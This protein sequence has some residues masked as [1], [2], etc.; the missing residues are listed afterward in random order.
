MGKVCIACGSGIAEPK[1]PMEESED[2]P[3]CGGNGT[4]KK[5]E[6]SEEGGSMESNESEASEGGSEESSTE[7]GG[8][9]GEKSS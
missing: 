7:E 9:E 3:N 4:V 8:S 6:S 2:C 1:K 5:E